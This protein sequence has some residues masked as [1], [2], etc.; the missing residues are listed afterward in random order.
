M[1]KLYKELCRYEVAMRIEPMGITENMVWIT[2]ETD[3]CMRRFP[4]DLNLLEAVPE[5]MEKSLI[6]LLEQ[7]VAYGLFES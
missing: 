7:F 6:K 5:Q 1:I 4:I 3:K 2:F